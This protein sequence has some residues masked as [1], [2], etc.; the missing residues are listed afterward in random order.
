VLDQFVKEGLFSRAETTDAAMA[1]RA[2]CVMLNKGA[3]L[4][5]AVTFLRDILTR[6]ERHHVKRFSR[7]TRLSAWG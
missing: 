5:E 7:Y 1:Q 6:M 4:V 2:D 3:H